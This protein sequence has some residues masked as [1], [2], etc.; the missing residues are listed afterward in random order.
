[1]HYLHNQD[2]RGPKI[3]TARG[4]P[5]CVEWSNRRRSTSA[6]KLGAKEKTSQV[7]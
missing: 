5:A 6:Q 7:Q 2:V 1:M 3:L 4:K